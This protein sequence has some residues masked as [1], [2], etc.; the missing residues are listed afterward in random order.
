M[1]SKEELVTMWRIKSGD[2]MIII[3]SRNS[4][5]SKR[6]GIGI[7]KWFMSGWRSSLL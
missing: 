6:A 4:L 1:V 3:Q 5:L 2:Y 7:W